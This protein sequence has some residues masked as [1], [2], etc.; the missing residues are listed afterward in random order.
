MITKEKVLID[1]KISKHLVLAPSLIFAIILYIILCGQYSR[2]DD[3]YNFYFQKAP[4]PGT[5]IQQGN[6]DAGKPDVTVSRPAEEAAKT[7]EPEAEATVAAAPAPPP[8][9][10]TGYELKKWIIGFH[11][12][13]TTKSEGNSNNSDF[14]PSKSESSSGLGLSLEYNLNRN[15]GVYG[16]AIFLTQTEY[17]KEYK[18]DYDSSYNYTYKTSR[19]P[20]GN[21]AWEGNLGLS[22]TPVRAPVRNRNVIDLGLTGGIMTAHLRNQQVAPYLG[23]RAALEMGPKWGVVLEA[24]SGGNGEQNVSQWIL[25]MQANI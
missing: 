23:A 5:V 9:P 21:N 8:P 20:E 18:S 24:R 3:V 4:G 13:G 19:T 12:A 15:F 7:A 1:E 25:G 22:W 11:A 10:F 17:E 6:G 14:G 2:A 16:T